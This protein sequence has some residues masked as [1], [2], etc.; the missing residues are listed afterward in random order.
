MADAHAFI[1]ENAAVA[2][3][4]FVPEIRLWLATEVTPLWHATEAWLAARDVPPPYWAF[5]WAGG[6][7]LA[8]YILDHPEIVRGKR[9]L[10]F[11][12]GSGLVA[13]AAAKAGAERV[14]PVDIDRVAV[15]AVAMNAALNGV[16]GVIADVVTDD[17]VGTSQP[18]FDV[19]LTG[20]VCYEAATAARV[21]PWLHT[22]ARDGATVVMADPGRAYA[23]TATVGSHAVTRLAELIVATPL[24]LE[25]ATEKR[26]TVF[27][28]T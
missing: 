23:P 10:D 20:D 7:A 19:V 11:G 21:L 26:C 16:A 5:A 12:A 27:A 6:Q 15:A 9:V 4:P 24:D 17:V 28:F 25:G 14:V 1:E 3:V 22:L 8:R 13:I 2:V 18:A